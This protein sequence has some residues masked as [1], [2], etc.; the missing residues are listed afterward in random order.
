MTPRDELLRLAE[1]WVEA[2]LDYEQSEGHHRHLPAKDAASAAF[3]SAL[4][5][6]LSTPSEETVERVAEAIA[7]ANG[8]PSWEQ[9]PITTADA[10]ES[11]RN[12]GTAYC[13][14]DYRLLAR[15]ALAASPPSPAPGETE[16]LITELR[17]WKETPGCSDDT[18]R[19][20]W[21]MHKAAAAL[22]EGEES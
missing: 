13:K 20:I 3:L 15:A 14:D 19:M 18:R 4:D 9:L 10:N 21:L 7:L 17:G 16:T 6:I 12:G 1:A 22:S 5:R 2:E 8:H 11:I